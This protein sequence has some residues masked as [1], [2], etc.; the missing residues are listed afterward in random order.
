M[1][2]T[3]GCGS[4]ESDDGWETPQ[5]GGSV[6][7]F[8]AASSLPFDAYSL[9]DDDLETM[10]T[11]QAQLLEACARSFGLE[12]AMGGDY[13]RPA[14]IAH[15]MWGGRLGTLDAAYAAEFG[16]HA[17]PESPWAPIGGF[18]LRDPGWV[19]PVDNGSGLG[20]A[21]SSLASMVL[22]GP[23]G[24]DDVPVPLDS[25]GQ[26]VPEG[27]CL[28]QVEA[29][30]GGP[31]VANT[32]TVA[33]LINLSLAHPDVEAASVAWSE[34]MASEGYDYDKVLDAVES[35]SAAGLSSGEIEVALADVECIEQS[36]WADYFYAVLADYQQQAI[37]RNPE[38][39]EAML[40]SQTERMAAL[41]LSGE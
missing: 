22:Y 33:E 26:P 3:A 23:T 19:T 16:Y 41:N 7:R 9:S 1:L 31:L 6:P 5:V 40:Q 14:D 2:L 24:G 30:I 11:A 28:A 4:E 27:G 13:V 10:Q 15:Y 29:E 34:C 18:Y 17:S 25:S 37:V 39:F 36:R 21:E 38:D 12:T 35:F 8:T 20:E 32:Q